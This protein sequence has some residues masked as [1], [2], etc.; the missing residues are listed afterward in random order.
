MFTEMSTNWKTVSYWK[1]RCLTEN[2]FSDYDSHFPPLNV[3]KKAKSFPFL[4]TEMK[5]RTKPVT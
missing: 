2:L 3:L 1:K 4:F 5:D